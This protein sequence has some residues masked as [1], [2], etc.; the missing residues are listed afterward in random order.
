MD[1]NEKLA[2]GATEHRIRKDEIAL[3]KAGSLTLEQVQKRARKRQR[4]SGM[5]PSEAY[6]AMIAGSRAEWRS[7]DQQKEEQRGKA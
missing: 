3:M 5:T 6:H 2:W 1:E 7:Q 4:Q